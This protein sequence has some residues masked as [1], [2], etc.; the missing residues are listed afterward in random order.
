MGLK[1]MIGIHTWKLHTYFLRPGYAVGDKCLRCG[2]WRKSAVKRA[3]R[4]REG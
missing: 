4:E 1:C 3:Y 2:I